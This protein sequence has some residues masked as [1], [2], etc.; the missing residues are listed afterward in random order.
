MANYYAK[1]E[2]NNKKAE[3]KMFEKRYKGRKRYKLCA[4]PI[5]FK[6]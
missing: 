2:H 5:K 3:V 6:Y 1:S 4:S